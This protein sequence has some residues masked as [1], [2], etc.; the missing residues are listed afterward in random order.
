MNRLVTST[1]C[2]AII[3][4][5]LIPLESFAQS[6]AAIVKTEFIYDQAPFPSCHAS[7]IVQT[8][9]DWLLPGSEG[10][11]KKSRCR[12]LGFTIR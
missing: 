12:D 6:R 10:L 2:V 7:T 9:A 4:T 5:I 8:K 11:M 1:M 3:V